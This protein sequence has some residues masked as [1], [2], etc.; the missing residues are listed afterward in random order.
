MNLSAAS[1]SEWQH[2]SDLRDFLQ[3]SEDEDTSGLELSEP[4]LDKEAEIMTYFNQHQKSSG[5]LSNQSCSKYSKTFFLVNWR[6]FPECST[7]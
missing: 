3:S 1:D 7:F 6:I 4:Q 5:H 2:P